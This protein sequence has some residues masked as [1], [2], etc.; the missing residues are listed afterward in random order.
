MQNI[1][2]SPD[3]SISP[4]PSPPVSPQT[5]LTM[6]SI[7]EGD[8]FVM[9][10]G[11]DQWVKAAV[12]MSLEPGDTLKTDNHSNAMIT[13][14]DGSTI[15]LQASSQVGVSE[16]NLARET[17][18]ITILLKQEIGKTLSRVTK[19]TDSASRYEVE[20]PAGVAAVR[21]SIML[22]QV[23]KNGATVTNQQGDIWAIAQGVELQI[24]EGAK[25][26]MVPGKA[27]SLLPG[28]G[29]ND[30]GGDDGGDGGGGSNS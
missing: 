25:G 29:S 27:P 2:S 1:P 15:E 4:V 14:F 24:P 3:S 5:E 6:L 22:L 17:G 12:G 18:T 10:S 16:Q 30:S 11:T 19:L 9:K 21:G 13:F 23:S 7:S 28:T 26:I 20:T 8:V